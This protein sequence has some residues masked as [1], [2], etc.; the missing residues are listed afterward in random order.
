[1]GWSFTPRPPVSCQIHEHLGNV[2]LPVPLLHNGT[3]KPAGRSVGR[4]QRFAALEAAPG[5]GAVRRAD[6]GLYAVL[7]FGPQFRRLEPHRLLHLD[8]RV[9]VIVFKEVVGDGTEA[10]SPVAEVVA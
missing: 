3:L 9:H 7:A 1:M 6:R 5:T 10:K 8:D 2:E 4:Q